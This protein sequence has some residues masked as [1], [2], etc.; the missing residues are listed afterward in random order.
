MVTLGGRAQIRDVV[1]IADAEPVAV[2]PAA[3]A[4]V[5]HAHGVAS[6]I[7]DRVP[8]YGRSTGVGANRLTDVSGEGD[9]GM[10]LLR[11]HAVD[12]G[13]RLPDR[14]VRAML[15]VRLNQLCVPGSGIDPDILTALEHMLNEDALPV[16][17]EYA[18]IGTG[19]LGALAG[20]ALTL[21]GERAA[22]RPLPAMPGWGA[23]SALPFISSNALTI[24]RACLSVQELAVLERA[25]S[26]VYVLSFLALEGN[27]EAFSEFAARASA[28]D[29]V[30]GIA[31]RVRGALSGADT[32][33][34]PA[35]RIQ[36]PFGLRV[37]T[38]TEGPLAESIATLE[39]K[40]T[41]LVNTAQENPLF[42]TRAFDDPTFDVSALD[43]STFD[44]SADDISAAAVVHHG[45]FFQAPLALALDATTLALAGTAPITHSRIGMMN[46]PAYTGQAPFLADGPAGSSGLMMV[47]Y[48]AAGAIAELRASAQP[49]S[50]GTLVLS[51]GVEED[52]SFASQG[53]VQLERAVAAYRVLL[54]CELVSAVR[55]L[56][57]RE[58]GGQ[59]RGVLREAMSI[60]EGL[61]A[62]RADRDLR[63]DIAMASAMLDG[64]G[65]LLEP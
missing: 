22:T 31:A 1:A 58:V 12:A 4:A 65:R 41:R 33:G 20:T 46:E 10:R 44:V 8:I 25:S 36:D 63:P 38:L 64:L 18:S 9:H 54:A 34:R 5:S 37:Y 47:E 21:I 35:A 52:A 2:D 48:V 15:A 7:A 60:V 11:S 57:R 27:D 19:D 50:L 61:P 53:A 55:L 62:E 49:A 56:R 3:I 32:A 59:W 6:G 26:M 24:G 51:R 45:A 17:L 43:V 28:T 16:V 23:D 13:G 14:T 40:L 42:D 30:I 39:E 29:S